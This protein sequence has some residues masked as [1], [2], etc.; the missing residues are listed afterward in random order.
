MGKMQ[1][2]NL[3]IE[4][5]IILNLIFMKMGGVDYVHA[6]PNRD[7]ESSFVNMEKNFI[8]PRE[9]KFLTSRFISY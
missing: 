8:I 3:N 1:L 2:G 6:D 9:E 7:K 5:R 4:G